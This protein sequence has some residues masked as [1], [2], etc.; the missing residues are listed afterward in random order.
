VL[1]ADEVRHAVSREW[2]RFVSLLRSLRDTD[3]EHPTQL[4]GW[5]VR[6]LVAHTVWGV[7]MEAD[8]LRRWRSGEPGVADGH[9]PD[10]GADPSKL[11]AEQVASCDDLVAQLAQLEAGDPTRP[12]P[13]PYGELPLELVLQIFTMEAGVHAHDLAI[14]RGTDHSLD[15]DI[16]RA[17]VVV[18]GSFLPVLAAASGE[19][20]PDGTSVALRSEMV[21]LRLRFEDGGWFIGPQSVSTDVISADDS[22]LVLFALGRAP[23]EALSGSRT[24]RLKFK[25]WFPGP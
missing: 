10:P 17:T 23:A 18:L 19:T 13:M 11:V 22:T 21:D 12:V 14:A 3:W 15:N 8:A 4:D 2:D 5:S 24:A 1:S 9:E 25:A 7:S 6:D 20:P 16:V